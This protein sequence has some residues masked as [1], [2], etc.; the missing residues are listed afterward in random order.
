MAPIFFDLCPPPLPSLAEFF[1]WGLEIQTNERY[2]RRLLPVLQTLPPI[3]P[4]EGGSQTPGPLSNFL[5]P[6]LTTKLNYTLW[7]SGSSS[8]QILP[9]CSSH[10]APRH[11]LAPPAPRR[12]VT[13]QPINRSFGKEE[14]SSYLASRPYKTKCPSRQGFSALRGPIALSRALLGPYASRRAFRPA[15][16]R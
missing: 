7:C 2:L 3:S 12:G 6:G 1:F 8:P 10:T 16:T 11:R 13:R 4:H 15:L 5:F 9:I 14:T